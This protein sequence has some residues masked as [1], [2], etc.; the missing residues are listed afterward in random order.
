M[1]A[2]LDSRHPKPTAGEH[3][4]PEI[5]KSLDAEDGS[6]SAL[7]AVAGARKPEPATLNPDAQN[8]KKST[9]PTGSASSV[10]S[11]GACACYS[12]SFQSM[13]ARIPLT[14]W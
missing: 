12:F 10:P 7:S 8:P 6:A 14:C 2:L 4:K 13:V 3:S 11:Q 1:S 5:L 9:R